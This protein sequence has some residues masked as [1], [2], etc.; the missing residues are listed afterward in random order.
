MWSGERP[1]AIDTRLVFRV[2]AMLSLLGGVAALAAGILWLRTTT[3]LPSGPAATLFGLIG[4][5]NWAFTF[6]ALAFSRLDDP[7]ARLRSLKLFATAHLAVG[8]FLTT[9]YL[10]FG[11][12][13]TR[14]DASLTRFDTVEAVAL[15]TWQSYQLTASVLLASAAVLAYIAWTASPG[16]RFSMT[17]RSTENAAAGQRSMALHEKAR[18][19]SVRRLRS[20]FEEQLRLTARRE[21]R[22]RIAR[23]LHDAVKQQLFVI[24][25]AAATIQTRFD[26]DAAGAREAVDQV[27]TA[28]RE[29][30]AEM[31]ALL[32]QLQAAPI[33]NVGLVEALKKQAEALGFR[34]GADVTV[35]TGALPPS[36]LLPPGAQEALFRVAQ[37]ALA[38]IG[39][40]ARAHRVTLTLRD[41]D[42]ALT[43]TIADDGAGFDPIHAPRG[44]GIENMQARAAE[45][46]GRL[47]ITSTPGRGTTIVFSVP[48]L[49]HS[50]RR[51]LITAVACGIAFVALA[52]LTAQAG[53][54]GP[55]PWL[56]AATGIAGIA[57][58]RHIVAFYRVR[59]MPGHA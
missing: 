52:V 22:A 36:H 46:G 16:S 26:T 59:S 38:N 42:G 12:T 7:A 35:D 25:T 11:S 49:A 20:Q 29:A 18:G 27:R 54:A 24:Q 43:L 50:P 10:Q 31:A 15:L 32:D 17:M 3:A 44:M 19:A 56:I 1:E 53:W 14:L 4:T 13:W 57:L 40:H 55:G 58:L 37:E 47:E 21:E 28:A 6:S 9:L 45:L 51:Y 34:T 8:L 2:Y 5:L 41:T 48:R 30:I 33:E 39:R 23:D